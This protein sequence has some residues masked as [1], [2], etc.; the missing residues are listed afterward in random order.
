MYTDLGVY[1]EHCAHWTQWH[2]LLIRYPH[3][4]KIIYAPVYLQVPHPQF[5]VS[6]DHH[7]SNP[8]VQPVGWRQKKLCLSRLLGRHP[9]I[10]A[11]S[12]IWG[13]CFGIDTPQIWWYA[14]LTQLYKCLK[15]IVVLN[16][17]LVQN[18]MKLRNIW[19][20]HLLKQ[21]MQHLQ[22]MPFNF[23]LSCKFAKL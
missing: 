13:G 10:S 19:K 22:K 1:I 12:A 14:I 7:C 11:D 8:S 4:C 18:D 17:L 2:L 3:H 6:I 16:I 5:Q 21:Y 15:Y 20:S 23:H 9:L